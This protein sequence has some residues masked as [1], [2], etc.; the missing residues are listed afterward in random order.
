MTYENAEQIARSMQDSDSQLS[1]HR[2]YNHLIELVHDKKAH[3]LV[4][5]EA[6]E[7]VIVLAEGP[8]KD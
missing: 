3:P 8:K 7:M 4:R 1:A 5:A 6:A 2:V